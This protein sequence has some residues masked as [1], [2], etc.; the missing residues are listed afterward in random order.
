MPSNQAAPILQYQPSCQEIALPLDTLPCLKCA[1]NDPQRMERLSE[2]LHYYFMISIRRIDP[3]ASMPWDS[4]LTLALNIF[5]ASRVMTFC[6]HEEFDIAMTRMHFVRAGHEMEFG[7]RFMVSVSMPFF[8]DF[9]LCKGGRIVAKIGKARKGQN[10]LP[11][12]VPPKSA[13]CSLPG[14]QY[15]SRHGSACSCLK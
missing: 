12:S 10:A 1:I 8:G 4:I 14:Q 9:C 6:A 2:G 7:N 11:V 5:H 3:S 13:M 15:Y